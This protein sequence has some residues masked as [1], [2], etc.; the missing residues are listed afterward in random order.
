MG[1]FDKLFY[2]TAIS[3]GMRH[4][5]KGYPHDRAI[6]EFVQ[7]IEL[8][9][10]LARELSA[11][12]PENGDVTIDVN[13]TDL[14]KA[15]AALAAVIEERGFLEKDQLSDEHLT[16]F[17]RL[18]LDFKAIERSTPAQQPLQLTFWEAE[19]VNIAEEKI[20]KLQ[21]RWGQVSEPLQT[22]M[23]HLQNKF[24]EIHVEHENARREHAALGF[25]LPEVMLPMKFYIP[26]MIGIGVSEFAFN[27]QAFRSLK[28]ITFKE[29]Y[30]IAAAPSFAFPFLAHLIGTKIRQGL[31]PGEK[32][33]RSMAV[34][35]LSI[36]CVLVG[37]ASV[38]YLRSQYLASK[39]TDVG[40]GSNLALL[41]INFLFL[42]AAMAASYVSH[43][44]DRRLENVIKRRQQLHDRMYKIWKKW[45][46]FAKRYDAERKRARDDIQ[47]VRDST[48]ALLDEYRLGVTSTMADPAKVPE[49]F[50]RPVTDLLFRPQN[51]GHEIDQS[52]PPLEISVD[53]EMGHEGGT[54]ETA[55]DA[56]EEREARAQEQE[57]TS[58]APAP[59]L[60]K[61]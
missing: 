49:C 56:A 61:G 41:G 9:R 8:T 51:F 39:G 24:S 57:S 18:L 7:P 25:R 14:T 28:G 4:G 35:T 42:G 55:E 27:A 3:W 17:V 15:K 12:L 37:L 54:E 43:D 32:R 60:V 46:N 19:H 29:I 33:V 47:G 1:W 30:M 38:L 2:P 11:L 16:E 44:H 21:K 48:R 26:L 36:T 6:R 31:L 45:G 22:E 53:W 5:R 52:P 59:P 20:T 58:P 13:D 50:S 10:N 40:M 23:K 34:F